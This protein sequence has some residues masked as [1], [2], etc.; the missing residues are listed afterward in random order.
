M[1]FNLVK[2][3][4]LLV[5]KYLLFMLVFSVIAPMFIMVKIGS[6]GGGLLGFFVTAL[7]IEFILLNTLS[8]LEDKYK[9]AA[10]LSATPYTRK[11][12]VKARYLFF[13]IIFGCV[14]VI[15][16][17]TSLVSPVPLEMLN[18][19]T[20]GLCLLFITAYF[21]ILLPIQ[22]KYGYEKTRYISFFLVFLTPFVGPFL[23]KWF[24]ANPLNLDGL[25]S[26]P[27]SAQNVL[28]ALIAVVLGLIS[29]ISSI[30]I[31]S[32]KNL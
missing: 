2:K 23:I 6:S 24:Q 17:I 32:Q 16:T 11:T 25:L 3:D 1:I 18:L 13:L 7:F 26:L 10:F 5:K 9:G 19:F 15:Y 12:L 28:P 4:L 21:G 22:Y 31:Y 8:S 20:A 30:N 29:M 14:C 27:Q